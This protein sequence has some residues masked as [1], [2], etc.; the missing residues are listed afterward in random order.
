M[1]YSVTFQHMYKICND[2][3]RVI[4]IIPHTFIIS[5][6]WEY[7][8][9]SLLVVWNIKFIIAN[10]N[11]SA[12]LE[13]IRS[14]HSFSFFFFLFSHSIRFFFLILLFICAYKAWVISPLT[15]TPSLT[16]HSAPSLFPLPPQYPAETILPL[17]LIL[18]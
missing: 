9:S 15:P 13:N 8:N 1:G 11:C 6:C 18:L 4:G 2:Q 5:L 14:Y 16:T 7:L 10:H 12:V 3:I 17:S